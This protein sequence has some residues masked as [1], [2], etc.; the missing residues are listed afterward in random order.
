MFGL[1]LCESELGQRWHASSGMPEHFPY[2]IHIVVVLYPECICFLYGWFSRQFS[3]P[4]YY[5]YVQIPLI[6]V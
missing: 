4:V 2:I 6:Y 3:F 1:P 5:T